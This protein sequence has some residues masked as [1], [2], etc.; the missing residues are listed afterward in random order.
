[1]SKTKQKF[2]FIFISVKDR[3]EQP[4]TYRVESNAGDTK[5]VHRNLVLDSFLPVVTTNNE[6]CDDD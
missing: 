4:H 6:L 5:V 2:N 3:N 1:M